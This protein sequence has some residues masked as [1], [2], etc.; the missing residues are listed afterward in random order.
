MK[1]TAIVTGGGSGIG[2]ATAQ[3]LHADGYEVF[4]V[5]LGEPEQRVEGIHYRELDVTDDEAVSG[6]FE[7]FERIDAIVNAAGI[8]DHNREW[9]LEGFSRVMDV[10]LTAVMRITNAALPGLKAARG[11][12]VN[13]ASM[14]AIFGSAKT[15]AYASSKAA[16]SELTRCMAVAW[17]TDGVRANA[18]APGWIMTNLSR[19]AFEDPTRSEGIMAR[20][21]MK[22]WGEPEDVANVIAFLVSDNA[23]YVTGAT[24]PVDGGY[25]IA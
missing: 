17:A 12:V 1:K 8:I 6:F 5:G 3:R 24:L 25:S 7:P 14:L 13:F 18:V 22:S 15:P 10:N 2:L 16:I 19:R 4:T 11:A 9:A 23:R 21:P 20:I